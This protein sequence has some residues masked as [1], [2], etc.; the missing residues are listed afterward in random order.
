VRLQRYGVQQIGARSWHAGRNV[1]TGEPDETGPIGQND[2]E[3]AIVHS[4]TLGRAIE[5]V[6]FGD[7]VPLEKFPR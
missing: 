4:A 5:S 2:F 7:E 6:N 3:I 1:G